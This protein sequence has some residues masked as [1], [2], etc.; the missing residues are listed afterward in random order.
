MV[1]VAGRP[2]EK[3]TAWRSWV[4]WSEAVRRS[5]AFEPQVKLL[6][7]VGNGSGIV[8]GTGKDTEFGVIF[9]MM[10]DVSGGEPLRDGTDRRQVEE[11]R[12]PLQVSMDDL[13]KR[14]SIFSFGIIGIIVFIGVI[15]HRSW[16]EMFTIGG[17]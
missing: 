14:L 17:A 11:K 2:W 6:I 4:L 7:T 8:V 15:Q 12:T 13:A 9:S 16:L 5:K 3:D 1:K 10:Q